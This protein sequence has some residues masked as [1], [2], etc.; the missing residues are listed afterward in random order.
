M[1]LSDKW[2]AAVVLAIIVAVWV[3]VALLVGVM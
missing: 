3:L 1:P 2:S